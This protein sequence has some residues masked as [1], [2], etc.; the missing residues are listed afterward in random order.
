MPPYPPTSY[1]PTSGGF[2]GYPP[3]PTTNNPSFPTFPTPYPSPYT[4]Y[5]NNNFPTP[6]PGTG[7]IKEEHIRY[8]I[9][10]FYLFLLKIVESFGVINYQEQR[11][12]QY[13]QLSGIL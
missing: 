12:S 1:P 3:Y 11:F 10:Q 8:G 6:T 5:P 2:G 7:T 9:I 4:P 13:L